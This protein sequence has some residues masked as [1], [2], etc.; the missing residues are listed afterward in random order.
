MNG[1]ISSPAPLLLLHYPPPL[2]PSLWPTTHAP[3]LLFLSLAQSLTQ[4]ELFRTIPPSSLCSTFP[5]RVSILSP[6]FLPL[7]FRCLFCDCS[8]P[9]GKSNLLNQI[10]MNK[11]MQHLTEELE[12]GSSPLMRSRTQDERRW[13][14]S[15]RRRSHSRTGGPSTIQESR[16]SGKSPQ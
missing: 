13:G 10:Q 8:R 4:I 5:S 2:L 7:F 14:S 11:R 12:W 6:F 16:L 3:N 1:L 9:C 15:E